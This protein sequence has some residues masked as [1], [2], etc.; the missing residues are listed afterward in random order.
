MGEGGIKS[1]RETER[2]SEGKRE[3]EV[4]KSETESRSQEV[5]K[6]GVRGSR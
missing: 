5:K 1:L 4:R 3:K 2:E 6:I